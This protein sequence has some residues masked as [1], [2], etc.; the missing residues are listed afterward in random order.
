MTPMSNTPAKPSPPPPMPYIDGILEHIAQG[1]SEGDV[2]WR[3]HLHWG[4]WE[5]PSTADG[6]PEDYAAAADRLTDLVFAAAKIADGMRIIDCGC[7]VGGAV[8]SLNERFSEVRL[9]GVNIDERQLAVAR[10]RVQAR[11]GN[12]VDFVHAD[13]CKLPFESESADVIVA[14]ECIFH[15]HSRRR[16]LREARRVLRPGGRLVITDIVPLALAMPLLG[17]AR[18][19]LSFY[20]KTNPMPT[21]VIAYEVLSRAM[22]MPIRDNTD[23]TKESLPTFEVLR[24]W[25]DRV[26]PEGGAQTDLM[27]KFF[28][29]GWVRYRLM[30]FER[31]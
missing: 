3:R 30:S 9:T 26:D 21:P 6:T 12:S 22:S 24:R 14:L 19:S 11:P 15:F 20:G 13:A 4:Y 16:F 31:A 8:A 17:Q 2:I 10:E 18:T 27:A 1:D 25:C 28:R 7:G 29:R 23:I 5:D